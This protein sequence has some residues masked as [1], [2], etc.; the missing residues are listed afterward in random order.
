VK[1]ILQLIQLYTLACELHDKGRSDCFQ[2]ISN[3]AQP[4]GITDPELIAIYWFCHLHQRFTKNAMHEF[5]RDYWLEYFPKLPAYQTFVARL[6]QL[7]PTFQAIGGQLQARLNAQQMAEL[8]QLIDSMPI[9][10]ARG[11]HAYSAKVAHETADIGYCA[12]KKL[13]F[14]GVKLNA[15][16]TRRSGHL[17]HPQEIWLREAS[18]NDLR[19]FKEQEL[20]VPLTTL[21]GDKAYCDKALAADLLEQGII[22]R[23]PQKQLKGKELNEWEKYYNQCVSRLRQPIEGFFNWLQKKTQIHVASMVRSDDALKIHC[24]G[25]LTVAYLIL[26]FN[27]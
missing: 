6:N 7:E 22:L 21:F 24:W 16:A 10:L 19:S 20:D 11:G 2:R 8:D 15:I 9:A 4:G 14:H 13:F 26:V 18:C 1:T 27:P 3:N 5:I 17:P 23:T 12:S 25:K